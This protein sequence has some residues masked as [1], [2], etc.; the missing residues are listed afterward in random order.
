MFLIFGDMTVVHDFKTL[1]SRVTLSW[2]LDGSYF[3]KVLRQ[4]RKRPKLQT[5]DGKQQEKLAKRGPYYHCATTNTH[6]VH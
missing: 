5:I 4:Q 6:S 2:H 3:L 1:Q